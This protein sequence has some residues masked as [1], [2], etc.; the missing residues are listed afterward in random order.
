MI[1]GIIFS[2]IYEKVSETLREG[3]IYKLNATISSDSY[4][5]DDAP[6]LI[7]NSIETAQ[8]AENTLPE[9]KTIYIKLKSETSPELEKVYRL[10]CENKGELEV[11]LC[12]ESTHKAAH[13]K[14]ISGIN[15]TDR[16]LSELELI[17]GKNNIITK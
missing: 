7:I 11:K 9:P 17:C 8:S 12:F 13:P 6:K 16:L 15:L 14:G 5:E 10:L 1:E 4:R 2:D 3:E